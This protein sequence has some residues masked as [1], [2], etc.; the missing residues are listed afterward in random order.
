LNAFR[1]HWFIGYPGEVY[2]MKT[3]I[4]Y[5][6]L[7]GNTERIAKAIG[8]AL[9][10]SGEVRVLRPGEVNPA[11]LGSFDLIFIGSPTQGGRQTLAMREFL[12]KIPANSLKNISFASFD[13]RIRTRLVK[14]FGYA[15]GRIAD[16]L[17]DRGGTLVAPPEGFFVK[18]TK[19]PLVDGEMERAAGW[20]KEIALVIRGEK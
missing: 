7:Y 6:T 13:T 1:V 4:I 8:E 12:G 19:G 2:L 15:G 3:L 5:D 16:S 10:P 9:I 14:V 18:S 11:E 17:K 20:A